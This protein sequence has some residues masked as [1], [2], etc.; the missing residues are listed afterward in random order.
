MN[1]SKVVTCCE[2]SVKCQKLGLSVYPEAPQ[3]GW[4]PTGKYGAIW[5]LFT[6]LDEVMLR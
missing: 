4:A 6:Q 5:A 3:L 2:V 1:N